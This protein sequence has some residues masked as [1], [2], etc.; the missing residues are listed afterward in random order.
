MD[1]QQFV[2]LLEGLLQRKPHRRLTIYLLLTL[3]S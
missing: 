2:Q 3:H 1:E